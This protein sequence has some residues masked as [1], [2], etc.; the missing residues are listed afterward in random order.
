VLVATGHESYGEGAWRQILGV[1]IMRVRLEGSLF[2]SFE[3]VEITPTG[4]LAETPVDPPLPV[5]HTTRIEL[6]GLRGEATVTAVHGIRGGKAYYSVRVVEFD[7]GLLGSIQRASEWYWAKTM[8]V[9]RD[10]PG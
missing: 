5:G 8:D 7:E 10:A 3:V 9:A 6:D 2:P 4:M 1:R